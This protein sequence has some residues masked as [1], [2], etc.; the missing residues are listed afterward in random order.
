[1]VF[2]KALSTFFKKM[3]N[4][5]ATNKKN[6]TKMV[7]DLPKPDVLKDPFEKQ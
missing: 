2:V 4:G 7:P 6:N 3:K 5:S 1:M